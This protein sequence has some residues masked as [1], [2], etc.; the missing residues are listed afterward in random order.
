MARADGAQGIRSWASRGLR[1]RLDFLHRERV[2][3]LLCRNTM[4]TAG[5]QELAGPRCP[6]SRHAPVVLT[7]GTDVR[8]KDGQFRVKRLLSQ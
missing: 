3:S 6:W 5:R 4:P 1:G 2:C 8:G 7:Q